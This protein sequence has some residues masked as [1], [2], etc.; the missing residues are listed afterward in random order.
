MEWA[1]GL[2]LTALIL[3]LVDYL[4]HRIDLSDAPKPAPDVD[5]IQHYRRHFRHLSAQRHDNILAMLTYARV[6]MWIVAAGLVFHDVTNIGARIIMVLFV[7]GRIRSLQEIGHHAAHGSLCPN[8][9]LGELVTNIVYQFP[10]FM[11]DI[12]DRHRIHVIEHH[13]SVNQP[14][15]PDLK[16]L[17][18]KG[19]V[20]GITE[21]NFWKGVLYPLTPQGI[22]DRLVECWGY[23]SSGVGT[24]KW[25]LRVTT[26]ILLVAFF[27]ATGLYDELLWLYIV[28]VLFTYPLF[29]WLAHIALHRWYAECDEGIAY[30][31]RELTLGRP[32]DFPGIVG[33]TIKSNL[34]PFGDSYHL[35]HS[36]FPSVRWNYLAQ[37]DKIVRSNSPLYAANASQGLV[38]SRNGRPSAISELKERM[39]RSIPSSPMRKWQS[40]HVENSELDL[41]GA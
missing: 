3:Q 17:I 7:T 10:A 20:P 12:R 22:R 19:F 9:T 21:F 35:A 15:D 40:D 24:Q 33:F 13:H 34:F 4:Y 11:P 23:L 32:T 36:L 16:E 6:Y 18:D 41:R 39:V 29:Y 2:A 1:F 31:K 26:V 38:F 25:A 8:R 28:P 14:F 5:A 30:H 27:M 37:V